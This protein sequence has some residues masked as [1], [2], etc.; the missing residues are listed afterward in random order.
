MQMQQ[1]H[2]IEAVLEEPLLA[3]P[4]PVAFSEPPL[5]PMPGLAPALQLGM[6]QP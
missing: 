1:M 5:I 2:R 6:L 4:P 3:P